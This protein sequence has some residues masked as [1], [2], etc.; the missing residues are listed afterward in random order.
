M[1]QMDEW[2]PPD[3]WI[4]FYGGFRVFMAFKVLLCPGKNASPQ[5]WSIF[6]A[7]HTLNTPKN[8]TCLISKS[9]LIKWKHQSRVQGLIWGARGPFLSA[10]AM[11]AMVVLVAVGRWRLMSD[12]PTVGMVKIVYG[13]IFNFYVDHIQSRLLIRQLKKEDLDLCTWFFRWFLCPMVW[14]TPMWVKNS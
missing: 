6:R 1:H 5:H 7:T 4:Q 13:R 8:Y 12:R 10:A 14:C 3:K 2:Q 9:S 11:V